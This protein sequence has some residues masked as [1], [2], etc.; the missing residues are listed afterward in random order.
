MLPCI[1][2]SVHYFIRWHAV[3][4]ELHLIIYT[5]TWAPRNTSTVKLVQTN[6]DA[7]KHQNMNS[8]HKLVEM[9]GSGQ[10]Q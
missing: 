3:L 9:Q 7:G 8:T 1:I 2:I 5:Q 10:D 4:R 6:N